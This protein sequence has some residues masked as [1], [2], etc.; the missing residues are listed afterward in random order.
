M[1][2][3]PTA[4]VAW[5]TARPEWGP[6]ADPRG[7]SW[8]VHSP[9]GW[10]AMKPSRARTPRSRTYVWYQLERK[11]PL[12]L[13]DCS[14]AL[15]VGLDFGPR[16]VPSVRVFVSKPHKLSLATLATG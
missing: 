13:G 9:P 15:R 14:P 7:G 16:L 3:S 8:P 4:A 6:L 10:A 1:G 5:S 2:D 12:L 11:A